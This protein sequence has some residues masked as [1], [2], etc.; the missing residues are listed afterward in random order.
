MAVKPETR[1]K[2]WETH[3]YE[4]A[5]PRPDH[6]GRIELT[7]LNHEKNNS[8]RRMQGLPDYDSEGAIVA[9][10]VKHHLIQHLEEHINNGLTPKANR[11]ALSKLLSR[12]IGW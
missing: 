11:F 12:L 2:Y 5:D 7:H 10:C 1:K 6:A 9:K 8:R 3:T 4:C